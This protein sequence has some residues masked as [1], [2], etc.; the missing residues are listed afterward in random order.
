METHETYDLL[1]DHTN[2]DGHEFIVP[3]YFNHI[4]SLFP[5]Y[6]AQKQPNTCFYQDLRNTDTENEFDNRKWEKY[7]NNSAIGTNKLKTTQTYI[8]NNN[9]SR[10]QEINGFCKCKTFSFSN[11]WLI[12]NFYLKGKNVRIKNLDSNICPFK[13][14]TIL[15]FTG[16]HQ[17]LLLCFSLIN[18]TT[19]IQ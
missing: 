12:L 7:V 16:E 17:N 13:H 4:I 14:E 1:Y 5:P 3:L 15:M 8:P 10:Q 18:S 2:L 19:V 11:V 6:L 9:I